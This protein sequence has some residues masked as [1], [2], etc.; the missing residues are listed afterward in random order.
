MTYLR[1]TEETITYVYQWALTIPNAIWWRNFSTSNVAWYTQKSIVTNLYR[2]SAMAGYP[3]TNTMEA[4][5]V[6]NN[7]GWGITT[8]LY[9]ASTAPWGIVNISLFRVEVEYTLN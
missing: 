9:N 6:C 2:T 4:G 3:S 1:S 7:Y 5:Q 8:Y